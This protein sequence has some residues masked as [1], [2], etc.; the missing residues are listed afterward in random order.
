MMQAISHYRFDAR[1]EGKAEAVRRL[2]EAGLKVEGKR[3]TENSLWARGPAGLE[4]SFLNHFRKLLS[5]M[6]ESN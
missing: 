5:K 3:A 6:P 1:I 4:S 2:I